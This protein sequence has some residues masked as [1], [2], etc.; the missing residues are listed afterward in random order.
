MKFKKILLWDFK[1]DTLPK[2]YWEQI[3]QLTEEKVLI[4]MDSP[5]IKNHL[6]ADCLLV[7][8]LPV[9]DKTIIDSMPNLKY[10]GILATGYSRIDH[11]Y[12]KEKN[13]VVCNIPG[14]SSESVAEFAFAVILEKIR[15]LER[16]KQTTRSGI[17]SQEGFTA[18][19]LRDKIFSVI[20]L[21]NIGSRIAEIALGFGCDVRYW[22]KHRKQK[23][24]NMGI[25]YQELDSLLKESDFISLNLSLNEETKEILNQERIQMIKPEALL[26]NLSPIEL[27]DP[28]ALLKRLEN[29]DITFIY[30]HS[31]EISKELNERFLQHKN[32][33][34]YPPIA[35]LSNEARERL[36]KIFI[37]N[38]K[39][40][41][42]G[43]VQ[44]KVNT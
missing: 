27:L 13:I 22:S 25:K 20:G 8:F 4:P 40:F 33:I 15:D 18:T 30:D 21:G 19:E 37:N 38:L 6:D 29:K 10:I 34:G 44:N 3:D 12:A 5:E 31:D 39:G 17:Y 7:R 24:E 28:N 32:C 11:V 26:L 35:Y 41:L 16:A 42:E 1:E 14:Y 43:K 9:V 36:R 23:Y 2:K